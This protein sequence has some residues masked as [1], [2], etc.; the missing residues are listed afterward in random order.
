M[1]IGLVHNEYGVYSGEEAMFYKIAELLKTNGHEVFLFCKSS[2]TIRSTLTDKIKAFFN[3]IYCGTSRREIRQMLQVFN[4]DIIQVQN[5]Y[6]LISPSVLLEIHLHRIP[7]IMRCANYRLICPNGLFLRNGQICRKC[8]GGREYWCA[9]TNCEG[10]L[11]KSLGYSLRNYAARVGGWYK[12][13]IR[14][15][16]TQTE[17]QRKLLIENGYDAKKIFT[18]PNMVDEPSENPNTEGFYV[19][20]LGRVSKEKGIQVVL[21]AAGFVNPIPFGVAGSLTPEYKH[22]QFPSNIY[23][24]GVIPKNLISDFISHSRFTVVPSICYEG[25]PSSI[26]ES[27]AHGRPVIC[28]N[29]GGLSEIIEDGKT[30][31]L[32]EPG[33]ARQLAQKVRYLWNNPQLCR[34]MGLRAQDVVRKQYSKELYYQRLIDLYHQAIHDYTPA[35]MTMATP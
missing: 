10:S 27:M 19:G 26:L 8:A 18:I 15:F 29:I 31:L 30:G 21:T 4:P 11:G 28:S 3:G 7:I 32:F 24:Q 34:R 22:I 35:E 9:L 17:F 13:T 5:L 33:N 16:Y 14:F 25:F 6:P 23:Y 12:N 2:R 1:R 20:Y